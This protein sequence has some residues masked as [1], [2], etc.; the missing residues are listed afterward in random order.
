MDNV[1]CLALNYALAMRNATAARARAESVMDL[2]NQARVFPPPDAG[3]QQT[4]DCFGWR[5]AQHLKVLT[6]YLAL[7]HTSDNVVVCDMDR[8]LTQKALRNIEV[9]ARN[10]VY[11]VAGVR[12]RQWFTT[13]MNFGTV[14]FRNIAAVR[15][16]SSHLI[17]RSRT[18]W[19]QQASACC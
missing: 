1:S 15:T 9:I 18:L 4:E 3:L 8:R 2:R 12:E 16:M 10:G 6:I 17:E 5:V 14:F 7:R 13:E 11:D 19:D